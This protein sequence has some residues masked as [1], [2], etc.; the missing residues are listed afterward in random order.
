MFS[1]QTMQFSPKCSYAVWS[2]SCFPFSSLSCFL[3]FLLSDLKFRGSCKFFLRGK[4]FNFR[5]LFW[6]LCIFLELFLFSHLFANPFPVSFPPVHWK[7]KF[8][9]VWT[10]VPLQN[11]RNTNCIGNHCACDKETWEILRICKPWGKRKL[12]TEE[13]KYW[14]FLVAPI[15]IHASKILHFSCFQLTNTHAIISRA[16]SY[17]SHFFKAFCKKSREKDMH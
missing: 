4:W 2:S 6:A 7:V 10:K 11:R 15:F 9:K 8:A 3:W 5:K 16:V 17:S 1:R 13:M 14:I 12:E